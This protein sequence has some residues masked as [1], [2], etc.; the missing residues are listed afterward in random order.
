MIFWKGFLGGDEK[1]R[2]LFPLTGVCPCFWNTPCSPAFLASVTAC[3]MRYW[4]VLELVSQDVHAFQKPTTGQPTL[5]TAEAPAP[6]SS[7]GDWWS[8]SAWHVIG[9]G[10]ARETK[11]NTKQKWKITKTNRK[12]KS[13]QNPT[14]FNPYMCVLYLWMTMVALPWTLK[15]VNTFLVLGNPNLDISRCGLTRSE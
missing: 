6:V 8:E 9:A 13:K 10:P 3:H 5:R 4:G 1:P 14:S 15:F 12:K 2:P 7:P 11:Q